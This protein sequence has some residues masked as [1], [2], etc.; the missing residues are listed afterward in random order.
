[1]DYSPKGNS[2]LVN[3]SETIPLLYIYRIAHCN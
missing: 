2:S 3:Q 1:M